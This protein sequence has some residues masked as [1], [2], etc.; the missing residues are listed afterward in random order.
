[1]T[2]ALIKEAIAVDDILT[3]KPLDNV[4]LAPSW[5]WTPY[6]GAK[7]SRPQ[8]DTSRFL[9]AH[10]SQAAGRL[11]L[12]YEFLDRDTVLHVKGK[13]VLTVETIAPP[14][15]PTKPTLDLLRGV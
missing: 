8:A 9:T 2:K 15:P 5:V 6:I 1:M 13:T 7:K 3:G 12:F 11:P 10:E 4:I 14:M